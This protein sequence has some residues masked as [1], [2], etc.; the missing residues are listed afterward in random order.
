MMNG[1]PNKITLHSELGNKWSEISKR[2]PGR[3][4]NCI[5]NHFN[6]LMRNGFRKINDYIREVKRKEV[7]VKVFKN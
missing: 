3:T 6:S 1:L 4:D 7:L 5:K 2:I